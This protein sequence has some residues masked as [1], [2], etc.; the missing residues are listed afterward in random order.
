MHPVQ[1]YKSIAD[2]TRLASLLLIQREGEICVCGINHRTG[3]E[4]T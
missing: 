2:D 3:T 4:P 1:F